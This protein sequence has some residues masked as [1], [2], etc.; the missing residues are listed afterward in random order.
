MPTTKHVTDL[1]HEQHQH[2]NELFDRVLAAPNPARKQE[3]F[4]ELRRYLAVHETAEELVTHPIARAGVDGSTVVDDRV[5]EEDMLKGLLAELDDIEVEDAAFDQKLENLHVQVRQ[6]IEY[7]EREEFPLLRNE[8]DESM[9]VQMAR[10]IEAVEQVAPTRPHP[11][12]GSGATSQ[13]MVGPLASVVDRTK[14]AIAKV[15]G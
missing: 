12:L 5:A 13:L 2:I 6:H 1:L 15:L 7:E 11:T 3:T 4:E 8:N 9:Q 14:D 10:A